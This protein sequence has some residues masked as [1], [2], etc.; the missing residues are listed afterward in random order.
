MVGKITV[1]REM[2]VNKECSYNIQYSTMRYRAF[3]YHMIRRNTIQHYTMYCDAGRPHTIPH[4]TIRCATVW[5]DTVRPLC[6]KIRC[7]VPHCSIADSKLHAKL[8]LNST[9][10]KNNVHALQEYQICV[11]D[12]SGLATC[13]VVVPTRYSSLRS[14]QFVNVDQ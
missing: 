1:T 9:H 5:C 4:D 6:R 7:Y 13:H 11:R 8:D 2:L 14:L 3:R 12:R 10:L